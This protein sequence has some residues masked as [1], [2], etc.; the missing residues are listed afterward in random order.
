MLQYLWIVD[1]LLCIILIMLAW[2][3]ITATDVFTAIVFFIVFGMVMSLIWARLEAP[4]IALAEAAIGAGLTGALLLS[5][6]A[7]T[8]K[9][10]PSYTESAA[11]SER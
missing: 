5:T 8:D 1:A 3:A 2:H 7:A 10:Q 9:H 11:P 6:W 4:D